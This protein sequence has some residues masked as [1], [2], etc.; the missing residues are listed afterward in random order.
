M[1]NTK[2]ADLPKA[3]ILISSANN[4]IIVIIVIKIVQGTPS[5]N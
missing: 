1:E 4:A 5:N 3:A 2:S